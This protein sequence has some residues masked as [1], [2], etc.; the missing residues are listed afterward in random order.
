MANMNNYG[1]IYK[2]LLDVVE[3]IFDWADEREIYLSTAYIQGS[4]NITA[5]L[6][7]RVRLSERVETNTCHI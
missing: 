6:A 3:L 4:L 5:D 7:S 1:S 2:H